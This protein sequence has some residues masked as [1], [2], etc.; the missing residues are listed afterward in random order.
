MSLQRAALILLIVATS[1][2]P[3]CGKKLPPRWVEPVPATP[4]YELTALYRADS[5]RLAW[6]HAGG[7]R[8]I[9]QRS[10]DGAAFTDIDV[11][12]EMAYTDLAGGPRYA[13][14]VAA[15]NPGASME[16]AAFSAIIAPGGA[17]K[18]VRP[19]ALR[20]E[21]K[22]E[23]V[24]LIWTY[25]GS[26]KFNVYE[27]DASSFKRIAGPIAEKSLSLPA[28]PARAAL[29]TVRA[30]SGDG[31]VAEGPSSDA[32]E[33]GPRQYVPAKVRNV[34]AATSGG[35]K[36]LVIWDASPESWVTLYRVYRAVGAGKYELVGSSKTPAFTDT[37]P[38]GAKFAYKVRAVGPEAEGPDS[39]VADV[40]PA[41][42]V[43]K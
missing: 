35:G 9:V 25:S 8:F 21:V 11:T 28:D 33:V 7:A 5:V 18:L 6:K 37:P 42:D 36:V 2:L 32:L 15:L 20:A 38:K 4:P 17:L 43:V 26:A 3:S 30:V 31:I 34:Q 41:P 39:G 24:Q 14:R 19:E 40:K 1:L 29:Y 23:S 13:Y 22:G 16:A 12:R 10:A 27:G